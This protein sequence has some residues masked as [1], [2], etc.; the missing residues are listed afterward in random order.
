MNVTIPIDRRMDLF[1]K[2]VTSNV[3]FSDE[4]WLQFS[5]N[6]N[7][8][9]VKKKEIILS[10]GEVCRFEAFVNKGCF[11]VYHIGNKG[12]EH[13][14][15]FAVEGWW[16]GDIDSFTN[17]IPAKLYIQALEDSEIWL[18]GKKDK[19]ALY[20]SLP[21][22][23]RLFRLMTQKRVVALQRR[24]IASMSKSAEE[25]YL[26]YLAAYP[27]IAERLTSRQIAAYLGISHEFL[28]KIRKKIS[29]RK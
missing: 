3:S 5:R 16:I 21:K 28:S 26:D 20:E 27:N 2:N 15:Y 4:E 18:I 17:Q 1:K 7:K 22:V 9:K 25:L 14:L 10:E 6:F 23:E 11:R 13:V 29:T 24:V 12:F 8:K 19:E